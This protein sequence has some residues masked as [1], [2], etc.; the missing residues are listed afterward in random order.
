[1][2]V[3]NFI[4]LIAI[5]FFIAFLLCYIGFIL[6]LIEAFRE[7]VAWGVVYWWV[8]LFGALIFYLKK[9]NKKKIRKSFFMMVTGWLMVLLGGAL[10]QQ[11][12]SGFQTSATFGSDL[13]SAQNTSESSSPST[14]EFNISPPPT[15]QSSPSNQPSPRIYAASVPGNK[16]EFKK[17]MKLGYVYYAQRDYQTAL[18]NFNKALQVLPGDAYAVK[19]VDNT[20]MAIAGSRTK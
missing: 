18:I 16:D 4:L 15:Q 7:D 12:H 14:I 19:A 20:K 1:M 8:P 17:S 11:A 13:N 10:L 5:Y 9:W 3:L 6:G 2:F